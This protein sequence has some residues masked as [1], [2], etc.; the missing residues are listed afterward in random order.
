MKTSARLHCLFATDVF[1]FNE[2]NNVNVFL[3]FEIFLV[4]LLL[5]IAPFYEKHSS[6]FD[7]VK[8]I[9]IIALHM[10]FK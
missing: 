5:M 8:N 3:C 4:I 7:S 6:N 1:A 9:L 2:Y 10:G